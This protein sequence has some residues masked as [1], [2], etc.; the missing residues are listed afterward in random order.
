MVSDFPKAVAAKGI[1][2]WKLAEETS[3]SITVLEQEQKPVSNGS[4]PLASVE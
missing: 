2:V 3:C 4:C 1:T